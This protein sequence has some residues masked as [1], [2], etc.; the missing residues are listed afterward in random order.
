VIISDDVPQACMR[1]LAITGAMNWSS[2]SHIWR[3]RHEWNRLTL[4]G[5]GFLPAPEASGV[6]D[7]ELAERDGSQF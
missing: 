5:A 4:M 2:D 6:D 3:C 7:G 1:P